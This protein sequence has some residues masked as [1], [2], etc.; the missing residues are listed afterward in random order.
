[1]TMVIYCVPVVLQLSQIPMGRGQK[2]VDK[3]FTAKTN[4]TPLHRAPESVI[5]STHAS[6]AMQEESFL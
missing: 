2:V 3:H 1:M 6:L 4:F 5:E